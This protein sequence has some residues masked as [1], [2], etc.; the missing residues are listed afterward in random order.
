MRSTFQIKFFPVPN[1]WIQPLTIAACLFGFAPVLMIASLAIA[2]R[3]METG[4]HIVGLSSAFGLVRELPD[5][6]A[7]VSVHYDPRMDA[8]D[9][10]YTSDL[11]RRKNI[12]IDAQT[13]Q[14]HESVSEVPARLTR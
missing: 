5:F 1:P 6:G 8:Y 9:F 7:F 14:E 11:G 12:A 4:D 3:P 13:G 10:T 2:D